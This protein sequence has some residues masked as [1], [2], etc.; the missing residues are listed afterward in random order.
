MF[1]IV[2]IE[3][4]G[5]NAQKNRITEVAIYLFDGQTIV[6]EFTSLINPETYIPSNITSLTGITNEMV[7]NAPKFFEV[8]RRIVE[9]TEGAFFV[10][11][12]VSFDYKF[13]QAEFKRLG[14]DYTRDTLCTVKLSRKY[15][16]GH[17]S[18]SL[19]SICSDL[20][21][22]INGRHRAAGDALA[23][24]NLFQLI[25]SFDVDFIKDSSGLG[26]KLVGSIDPEIIKGLPESTG[27]YY[28]YNDQGDILYIGK[29]NNIRKRVIDH[30]ARPT[31]K[32]A[33]EMASQV[34]DIG[35][36]IT[37]S[38]IIAL[39]LEADQ[40]KLHLPKYNKRGRRSSAQFG[41]ATQYDDKGY[42]NIL[43]E[44]L[45]Q[46]NNNLVACF[47]DFKHAQST[48]YKMVDVYNLCQKLCGLYNSSN[49][50]FHYQIG[51]CRGAC[52]GEE[53]A[54]LYNQRAIKAMQSLGLDSRSF[55]LIDEGRNIDEKSFV[56]IIN[57]KIEGFGF[58]NPEYISRVEEVLEQTITPCG[59]HR[60]AI[61]AVKSL[62]GKSSVKIIEIS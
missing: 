53:P 31:S 13:I 45:N 61:Y 44:K 17:A 33:T 30:L 43:I 24:V 62:M 2:D 11:H 34:F 12:N 52:V 16:P 59:N 1:A 54:H 40:I 38:E 41:I 58:F 42:L 14:Y 7:A 35:F 56:K 55:L 9:I 4:T 6:D 23:T 29:S 15:L 5:G 28:L 50:C 26:S 37:G 21:I 51:Q 20:R 10:A 22:P 46:E 3:T 47:E 19:G 39:I 57:G 49:A 48:L 32:R 36:E 18:Y 25:L 8:A 27:V 60:E